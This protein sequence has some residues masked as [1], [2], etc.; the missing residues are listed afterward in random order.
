ML[1]LPRVNRLILVSTKIKISLWFFCLW[2]TPEER[3]TLK[4]ALSCNLVPRVSLVPFLGE[5]HRL[6]ERGWL[7]WTQFALV[8]CVW[9]V[10]VTLVTSMIRSARHSLSLPH[11]WL[12]FPWIR[13]LIDYKLVWV[14]NDKPALFFWE[15]TSITRRYSLLFAVS[16]RKVWNLWSVVRQLHF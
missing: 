5:E 11:L 12:F 7:S 2:S 14:I 3:S 4:P 8:I 10:C 13:S 1:R 16:W 6:C 9:V 15:R